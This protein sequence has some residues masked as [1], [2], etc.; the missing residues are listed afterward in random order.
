MTNKK[1]RVRKYVRV[2]YFR[3]HTLGDIKGL[4]DSIST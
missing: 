4:K 3:T 2:R 1:K